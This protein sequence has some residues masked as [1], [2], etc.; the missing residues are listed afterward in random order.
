MSKVDKRKAALI[1]AVY[2]IF[3]LGALYLFLKYAFW[4]FFP[5]I[6]GFFVA[7]ILQKPINFTVKKT[8]VKKGIV[9]VFFVIVFF[10]VIGCLMSLIGM[11]IIEEFKNFWNILRGW[12]TD[13]SSIVDSIRERLLVLADK[14]P[15]SM[16]ASAKEWLNSNLGGVIEAGT[17]AESAKSSAN[18]AAGLLSKID[19]SILKTPIN[20]VI[21]TA[22]QIPSILVATI[23]S[24][25]SCFFMTSGYDD[26]VKFIKRQLPIGKRKALTSA[27]EIFFFSLSKMAKSYSLIILITF[28]EMAIG[29]NVLKLI[30]VYKFD[31]I[32][33]ISFVTALIDIFPVLGTGTILIPWSIYSFIMGNTGMGIGILV[34]Y[35]VIS[36][37][38]QIIEPKLVASNLGLPPIATIMSMYIGIQLFGFIGLFIMPIL[39]TLIKLLND[40]GII[41]IW[42]TEK[43][44]NAELAALDEDEED[45]EEDTEEAEEKTK[46]E[47]KEKDK[48]KSKKIKV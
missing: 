24:I 35:A 16:S 47:T 29:L 41:N 9:S 8:R 26:M 18:A 13:W 21:S 45:G 17:Q 46:E 40:D 37:I 36:V 6:F 44:E 7:A 20:G 38:R 33:V 5:F 42:K 30:G 1:N 22:K 23:I 10:A 32:I 39:L 19:I 15:E 4:L 43:Q 31:Y 34:I 11:R 28:S 3:I 12:I 48:G 2:A 25:I 14:L 27:K